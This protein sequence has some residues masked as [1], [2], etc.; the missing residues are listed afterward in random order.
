MRERF[1]KYQP[2]TKSDFY[3]TL[4]K[5]VHS[6]LHK[7][8]NTSFANKGMLLKIAF[9]LS[10]FI[11]AYSRYINAD[12][13]YIEWLAWCL[14]LGFASFL[15]GVNIGHDAVHQTLFKKKLLNNLAGF[16][17]DLIGISSYMW[18]LK[19][20]VVHHRFPNVAEVDFD[21]E[22]GPVLRLSPTEKKDGF[23]LTS[24]CMRRW[25]ISSSVFT[26]CWQTMSNYCLKAGEK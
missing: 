3:K 18:R 11:F 2:H 7:K 4:Q 26:L 19:H 8:S 21:I 5:E 23:M 1:A 24:I 25:C 17:F 14:L 20:N 13:T 10:L 9:C 22:A 15:A 12:Q 6:H 16:S